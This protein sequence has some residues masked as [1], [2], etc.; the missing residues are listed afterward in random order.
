MAPHALLRTLVYKQG[1]GHLES[2]WRKRWCLC[3]CRHFVG[4]ETQE[5]TTCDMLCNSQVCLLQRHHCTTTHTQ[6]TMLCQTDGK[7]GIRKRH[8]Q[9]IW[10]ASICMQGGGKGNKSMQVTPHILH[11]S[12]MN[13]LRHHIGATFQCI[14][15]L[16]LVHGLFALDQHMKC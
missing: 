13:Q 15:Q 7:H 1:A 8:S 11:A 2:G 3:C 14:F 9:G 10:H 6:V 5:E 16:L 4:T 12:T